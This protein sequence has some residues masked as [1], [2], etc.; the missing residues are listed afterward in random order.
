MCV[1]RPVGTRGGVGWMRGPCACP[2]PRATILPHGTPTHRRATRT[3]TRPPPCHP[4][5]PCPYR[6]GRRIPE[7]GRSKPSGRGRTIP[8]CG[9]QTSSGRV[10]HISP[11]GRQHSVGARVVEW[12]LGGPLWS[13]NRHQLNRKLINIRRGEGGEAWRGGP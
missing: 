7:F 12:M 1:P 11:F 5:A 2:P 8:L 13:P 3:S 6:T 10:T 9:Y 4:S